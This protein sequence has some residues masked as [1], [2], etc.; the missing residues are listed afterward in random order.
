MA[1]SCML[2]ILTSLIWPFYIARKCVI[3]SSRQRISR[4]GPAAQRHGCSW[5]GTNSRKW[6]QMC[7]WESK[8]KQNSAFLNAL[9][10]VQYTMVVKS[11]LLTST[12]DSYRMLNVVYFDSDNMSLDL[13]L[14]DAWKGIEEGFQIAISFWSTR[15]QYDT[16]QLLRPKLPWTMDTQANEANELAWYTEL[17]SESAESLVFLWFSH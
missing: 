6:R 5:P 4:I 12:F 16:V 1:L 17:N 9:I 8:C 2:F 13:S 3:F 10:C 15:S 14:L 7:S 11:V